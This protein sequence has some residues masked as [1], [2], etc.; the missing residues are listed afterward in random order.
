MH[1]SNIAATLCTCIFL[2]GV[3]EGGQGEAV[4]PPLFKKE[5]A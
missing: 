5:E 1:K 3:G 2:R 4:F